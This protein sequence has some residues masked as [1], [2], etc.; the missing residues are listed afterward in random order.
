M[1][2]AAD[3]SPYLA[4]IMV[5]FYRYSAGVKGC[6]AAGIVIASFF[7]LAEDGIRDATVTGVQTCALPIYLRFPGGGL[8]PLPTFFK[9]SDVPATFPLS[10]QRRADFSRFLS[11]GLFQPFR[12]DGFFGVLTTDPPAGQSIYH[13]GSVDVIHRFTHGLYLR[14]NYTFSKTMDDAT[15]ELNSSTINP[16]RPQDARNVSADRGRSLLDFN[17]KLAISWVYDLP[18]VRAEKAF[19]KGILHGWEVSGSYLAQS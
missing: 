18:N 15:N 10:S 19:M 11:A 4:W 6:I 7:V 8:T 17:H 5:D 2:S 12:A 14:G 16:R 3:W 1:P 13:S 9:A